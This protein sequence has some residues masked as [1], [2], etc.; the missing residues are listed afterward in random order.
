MFYKLSMR[1]HAHIW[2]LPPQID[3]MAPSSKAHVHEGSNNL[4]LSLNSYLADFGRAPGQVQ[5]NGEWISLLEL[6]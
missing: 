5:W 2:P 4:V 1:G 6:S 3:N